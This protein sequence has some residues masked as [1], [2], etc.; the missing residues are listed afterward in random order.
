MLNSVSLLEHTLVPNSNSVLWGVVTNLKFLLLVC[1]HFY[2]I[3][4]TN[5]PV[6][7]AL[8]ERQVH[9]AC[10][11]HTV[12]GEKVHLGTK[13]CRTVKKSTCSLINC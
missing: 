8:K 11:I 7:T 12:V 6:H 13:Q 2:N 5:E 3:V 1:L 10:I 4:T 9:D